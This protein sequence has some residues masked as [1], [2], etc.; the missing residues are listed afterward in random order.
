MLKKLAQWYLK[1]ELSTLREE[2]DEADLAAR[3]L[4]IEKGVN[5]N[6]INR[7][8]TELLGKDL[9]LS[10]RM[11][12]VNADA[13][14]P[15]PYGEGRENYVMHVANFYTIFKPKL[16]QM[17][18]EVREELDNITDTVVPPGMSRHQYDNFLRGTSN[19]FKLL[20]DWCERLSG[21]HL[22][23]VTPP[24]SNQ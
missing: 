1:D 23:N 5:E 2:R 9:L 10:R 21:E 15:E 24:E 8:R 3:D 18:A 13:G 6:E 17:I 20:M 11:A 16:L 7:L 19:A 14:D 4:R 22:R 12:I